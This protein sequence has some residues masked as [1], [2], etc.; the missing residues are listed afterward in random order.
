MLASGTANGRD[1]W[2][3]SHDTI[4]GA[5]HQRAHR[6]HHRCICAFT[7]RETARCRKRFA[8][9]ILG[10]LGEGWPPFQT[11]QTRFYNYVTIY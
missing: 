4:L 1:R 7:K 9:S 5:V 10:Q 11:T 8:G 6:T 3:S 2:A